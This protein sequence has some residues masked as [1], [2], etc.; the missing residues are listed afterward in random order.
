MC[1][2]ETNQIL[3]NTL[4]QT[5]LRYMFQ[6]IYISLSLTVYLNIEDLAVV[7]DRIH[8]DTKVKLCTYNRA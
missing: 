1:I 3:L 5:I 8:L 4:P 6:F 2:T 7:G